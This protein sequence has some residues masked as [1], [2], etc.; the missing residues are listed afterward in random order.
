[1]ILKAKIFFPFPST[2]LCMAKLFLHATSVETH[3]N[4]L[5]E[6]ADMRTQLCFIRP[7]T[8]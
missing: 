8:V 3:C 5:N 7:D 6:E 4:I 1:M 2:R